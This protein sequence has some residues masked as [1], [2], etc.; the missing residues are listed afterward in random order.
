MALKSI[1]VDID[2]DD[3]IEFINDYGDVVN[4]T[5][6]IHKA[7]DKLKSENTA[8]IPGLWDTITHLQCEHRTAVQQLAAKELQ[9]LILQLGPEEIVNRIKATT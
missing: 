7:N 9:E 2:L 4:L 8:P 6:I 3:V 5:T 1:D